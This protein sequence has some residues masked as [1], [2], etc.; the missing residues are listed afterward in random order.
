MQC[1]VLDYDSRGK[2]DFI[3]EFYTTF[4]EMQKATG[5][6]K[7][8][9]QGGGHAAPPPGS[10]TAGEGA[11]WRESSHPQGLAGSGLCADMNGPAGIKRDP[12]RPSPH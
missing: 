9:A 1:V 8:G 3:G 11:S 4:E 7:V 6:N 2:H 5:G 10:S 12:F